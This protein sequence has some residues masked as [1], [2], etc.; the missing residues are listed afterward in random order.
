[1]L[2]LGDGTLGC[3][4]P[5][6]RSFGPAVLTSSTTVSVSTKG[7]HGFRPP[8]RR[9]AHQG[10]ERARVLR[11][12]SRSVRGGVRK[13][14]P[15]AQ[16]SA[17]NY[18]QARRTGGYTQVQCRRSGRSWP[19]WRAAFQ[20]PGVGIRIDQAVQVMLTCCGACCALG[21]LTVTLPLSRILLTVTVSCPPAAM[22]P[23][24]GLIW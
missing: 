1:M 3:F 16:A 6:L 9:A 18:A 10:G 8:P 21:A 17:A 19:P 14:T 2:E 13:H 4:L 24:P 15:C 22:L 11:W 20:A 23:L 5:R 12:Q 7:Y